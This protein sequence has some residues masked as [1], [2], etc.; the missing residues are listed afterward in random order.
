[1][2]ASNGGNTLTPGQSLT[3]GISRNVTW[4]SPDNLITHNGLLWELEA[5]EVVARARP[6]PR[7]SPIAPVEKQVLIEESV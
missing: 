2:I 5:V 1:M 4:W 3:G 6:L 7:V